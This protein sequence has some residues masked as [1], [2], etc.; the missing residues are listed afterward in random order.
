MFSENK[1]YLSH[2]LLKRITKKRSL[3]SKERSDQVSHD[4]EAE[5]KHELRDPEGLIFVCRGFPR[6]DIISVRADE[7]EENERTGQKNSGIAA[8][9]G[10]EIEPNER[11]QHTG[12][13]AAGA[14]ETRDQTEKAGNTDIRKGNEEVVRKSDEK[15]DPVA[16]GDSEE[17][18]FHTRSAAFHSLVDGILNECV[19][20]D[21]YAEDHEN[22]IKNRAVAALGTA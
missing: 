2:F 13:A 17:S 6:S 14:L 18:L 15:Q 7:E 1:S 9:C 22:E 5:Q 10:N 3:Q 16:Q 11:D 8:E 4:A 21:T 19:V 12:D 20:D